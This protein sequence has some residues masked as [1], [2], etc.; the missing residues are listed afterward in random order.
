M[1]GGG[2]MARH[3]APAPDRGLPGRSL[4]INE[5]AVQKGMAAVRGT[6]DYHIKNKKMSAAELDAMLAKQLVTT[7]AL[8][9]IRGA[10]LVIEAVLED[11]KVKQEIWKKLEGICRQEAIFATNTSALPITEMAAS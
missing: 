9:D 11:M 7:S 2:V 4:D 1:L 5:A 8:E 6:F 3:R 10:D